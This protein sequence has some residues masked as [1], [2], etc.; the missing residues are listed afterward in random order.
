MICVCGVGAHTKTYMIS[1]ISNASKLFRV[2]HSDPN[3]APSFK[4]DIWVDFNRYGE[5]VNKFN[6]LRN[7]R[8]SGKHARK[9]WNIIFYLL[10]I[11]KYT[12]IL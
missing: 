1:T 6:Q 3:C 4:P 7:Y 2:V 9:Y 12:R 11:H 5:C 8:I 10:D